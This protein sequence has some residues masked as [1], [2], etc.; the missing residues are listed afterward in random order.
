MPL[1]A[2]YLTQYAIYAFIAFFVV[3]INV[4]MSGDVTSPKK[5]Y[6]QFPNTFQIKR[7]FSSENMLNSYLTISHAK[8]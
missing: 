1:Y 2:Y 8:F 4:N 5:E 6:F 7:F 3:A